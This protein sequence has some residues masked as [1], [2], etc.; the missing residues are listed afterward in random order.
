[1]LGSSEFETYNPENDI[2]KAVFDYGKLV[3]KKYNKHIEKS[4]VKIDG[5]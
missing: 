3:L 4:E 1:M 5:A 2:L